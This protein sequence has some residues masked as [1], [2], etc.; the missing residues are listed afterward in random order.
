MIDIYHFLKLSRQYLAEFS[1]QV[2]GFDY[3]KV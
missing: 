3:G 1:E 2:L